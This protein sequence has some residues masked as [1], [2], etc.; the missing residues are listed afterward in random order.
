MKILKLIKIN[1]TTVDDVEIGYL[2]KFTNEEI[3]RFFE[4]ITW[5]IKQLR[6][7]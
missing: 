3:I 4:D 1:Y 5:Y 2:R 6:S 7:F